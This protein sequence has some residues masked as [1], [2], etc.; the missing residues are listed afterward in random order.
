MHAAR[1]AML[2]PPRTTRGSES[3]LRTRSPARSV[4]ADRRFLAKQIEEL[5]SK[6]ATD[7]GRGRAWRDRSI[8]R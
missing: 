8:D 3:R 6:G 5:A 2:R 1:G 7:P 4:G